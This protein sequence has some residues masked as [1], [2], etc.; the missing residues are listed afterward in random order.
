MGSHNNFTIFEVKHIRQFPVKEQGN[1]NFYTKQIVVTDIYGNKT[2]IDL[3][4]KYKDD[5]MIK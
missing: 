5:L 3:F 1:A 4:G 2:Y